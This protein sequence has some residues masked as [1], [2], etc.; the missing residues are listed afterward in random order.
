MTVQEHKDIITNRSEVKNIEKIFC[1]KCFERLIFH[2][3]DNA[4]EFAVGLYN[5]I[6][7]ILCAVENG[8]LPKLPSSWVQ[9]IDD[10]YRTKFVFD[11]N[12][13]YNDY[14]IIKTEKNNNEI[15]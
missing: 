9:A 11:E 8:Y 13:C 2:M 15:F 10:I 4:H 1:D 14:D 5:I 3:Q 12:L 6:E 7:C